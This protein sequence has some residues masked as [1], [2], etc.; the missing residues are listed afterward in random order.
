[1]KKSGQIQITFNWVYILI[2]GA[3][4]LLFFAGLV[5][6]QK[7]VSEQNL[8]TDIV[9]ILDSIFTSAGVSS[10][11]KVF[12]DTSGL[13]S[14]TIFF[15][16]QDRVGEL[17]IK[18]QG[19]SIQ[20]AVDPIF[21]PA[22]VQTTGLIL[23]S[24]PYKLPYKVIDFLYIIPANAK[25]YLLG[26]DNDF[27]REFT[28]ST[29]DESPRLNI[30]TE[31]ISSL[32]EIKPTSG[33]LLRLVDLQGNLIVPGP[34]PSD[35]AGSSA[36]AVS[37]TAAGLNFY[38]EKNG[39]WDLLNQE[40]PLPLISLGGE[41]DAAKHAAI[42]SSDADNYWCN[43]QK[44]FHRLQYVTEVY[45]G[46]EEEMDDFYTENGGVCK[47]LLSAQDN[48]RSNLLTLQTQ[49]Q[50]CRY[51]YSCADMIKTAARIK[52]LDN[53]LWESHCIRLY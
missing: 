32:N 9:N 37:F 43:M 41:K 29:S 8:A 18:G 44:A 11:T 23:W 34:V 53:Q 31:F 28:N 51:A 52:T 4:I 3:I 19:Q 47:V 22:E 12:L 45:R 7:A 25:Y 33:I 15:N 39:R 40:G 48:L 26:A 30:N 6:K 49:A 36:T 17:G 38:Q 42:F 10:Q 5:I 50:S 21:S 2:A 24:L 13:S 20:N 14:Y 16:C 1:M 46:K 35:L 27:V